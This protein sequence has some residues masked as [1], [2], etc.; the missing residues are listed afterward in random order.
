MDPRYIRSIMPHFQ[1]Q[2]V[3]AP[4]PIRML[5]EAMDSVERSRMAQEEL[6]MAKHRSRSQSRREALQEK[7]MQFELDTAPE[8]RKLKHS[9]LDK[10]LLEKILSSQSR[11]KLEELEAGEFPREAAR[12][13]KESEERIASSR[14][15]RSSQERHSRS[16]EKYYDA[17]SEN[18]RGKGKGD[19]GL[20]GIIDDIEALLENDSLA[21][22]QKGSLL[23][24]LAQQA[25]KI[26]GEKARRL[27]APYLA[28]FAEDTKADSIRSKMRAF[29]DPKG[30]L[31]ELPEKSGSKNQWLK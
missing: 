10:E 17:M 14:S 6:E 20:E 28:T 4:N 19:T 23:L 7:A 8:D 12:K 11:R 2:A 3:D 16:Q 25:L 9:R 27:I 5:L 22:P 31:K 30:S 26:G 15:H 1:D 24:K 18:L 29:L 13:G 21:D